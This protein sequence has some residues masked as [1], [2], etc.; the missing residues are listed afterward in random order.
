MAVTFYKD[1]N[2]IPE[3]V[4]MM[5]T[6]TYNHPSNVDTLKCTSPHFHVYIYGF[7]K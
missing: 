3:S 6:L 2:I 7:D 1:L 4:A 5:V